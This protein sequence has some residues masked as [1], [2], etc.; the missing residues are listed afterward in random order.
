M[1][2]PSFCMVESLPPWERVP[3]APPEGRMRQLVG[4]RTQMGDCGNLIPHPALRGY[5]P[6]GGRQGI[7][8]PVSPSTGCGCNGS[9]QSPCRGVGG[10]VGLGDGLEVQHYAGHLLNLLL[11]GLA[12]AGDGLRGLHGCV[13]VDR[14]AALRRSQHND[15]AGLGHADDGGLVVLVVQLFRWR[16]PRAR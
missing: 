9:G 14:H 2:Y 1:V 15:A 4:Y 13:F 5:L 3:E 7:I 10:I 8:S 11:H 12:V 16:G 6:P